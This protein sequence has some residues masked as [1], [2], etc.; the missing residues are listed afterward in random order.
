VAEIARVLR[1][2]GVFAD[3]FN[4]TQEPSPFPPEYQA[5]LD[6]IFSELRTGAQDDV[7]AAVI[8]RGPFRDLRTDT[9]AHEQVQ[10]RESCLTFMRSIS[11]VAKRPEDEREALMAELGALLPPGEYR[12]P[13]LATVRWAVRV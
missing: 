6:E 8:E 5:K 13:I 12:F 3:V 4:E 2:G 1:P 11:Y 7:R 9:V 10:S